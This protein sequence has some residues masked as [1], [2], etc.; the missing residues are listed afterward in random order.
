MFFAALSIVAN[1]SH[2]C[3]SCEHIKV[4]QSPLN[5]DWNNFHSAQTHEFSQE[6]EMKGLPAKTDYKDNKEIIKSSLFTFCI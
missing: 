3:W 5:T 4:N 2:V 6:W 1:H